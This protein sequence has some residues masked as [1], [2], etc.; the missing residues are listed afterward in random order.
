MKPDQILAS[1]SQLAHQKRPVTLVAIAFFSLVCLSLAGMQG[2]S[3]YQARQDQLAAAEAATT[4]M[5]RALADQLG[6]ALGAADAML[7]DLGDQVEAGIDNDTVQRLARGMAQRVQRNALVAELSVYDENG[8]PAMSSGTA[9]P[10]HALAA[11]IVRHGAD[12]S[13]APYIGK[14]LRDAAG[15]P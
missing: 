4:A 13:A 3:V 12:P 11:H 7:A 8:N 14:P 2:W 6:H 9:T 1:L 10:S 15:K 5:T